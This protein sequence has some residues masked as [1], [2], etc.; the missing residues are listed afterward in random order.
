MAYCP[1]CGG[2]MGMLAVKCPHCGYDWPIV[3]GRPWQYTLAG[4]LL[5]TAGCALFMG[6]WRVFGTFVI[7][8]YL[9]A[10]LV[11]AGKAHYE[12]PWGSRVGMSVVMVVVQLLAAVLVA[13]LRLPEHLFGIVVFGPIMWLQWCPSHYFT[14]FMRVL[15]EP[16]GCLILF[17]LQVAFWLAINILLSWARWVVFRR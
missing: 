13:A 5:L 16:V 7:P 8:A 14:A 17:V 12:T 15:T 10:V 6:L 2:Q 3:R 4:L 9:T 11:F 1:K